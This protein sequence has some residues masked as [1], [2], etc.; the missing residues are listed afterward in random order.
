MRWLFAGVHVTGRMQRSTLELGA[1]ADEPCDA[2]SGEG[3]VSVMRA[4]RGT[5]GRTGEQT[6]RERRGCAGRAEG[7]KG[8]GERLQCAVGGRTWGVGVDAGV[9]AGAGAGQ[10]RWTRNSH[11]LLALEGA[12]W[13]Y[14]LGGR[15][16]RLLG[17]LG[18]LW[19]MSL[20]TVCDVECLGGVHDGRWREQPEGGAR[21][22]GSVV[23]GSAAG[24]ARAGS[25]VLLLAVR[26]AGERQWM[27]NRR[28][29][30]RA[31]VGVSG[32]R[33]HRS[34]HSKHST[35]TS[36]TTALLARDG[37]TLA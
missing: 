23:A 13:A 30:C 20:S 31:C 10:T 22:V 27:V 11:R 24:G 29:S 21:R 37:A 7:R 4:A 6:G 3:V 28:S 36:T 26:S 2:V 18:A 17:G 19:Q 35:S 12:G 33:A 16:V 5:R 32:G 34:T 9:D 25:C 1:W 15:L 14:R 8:E